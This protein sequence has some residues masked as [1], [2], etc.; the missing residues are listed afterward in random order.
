VL[1]VD[2]KAVRET[3]NPRRGET[4]SDA[5]ESPGPRREGRQRAVHA[6]TDPSNDCPGGQ[7]VN[8]RENADED[9]DPELF[10]RLHRRILRI[11]RSQ[12]RGLGSGRA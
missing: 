6:L 4:Q 3:R 5:S 12:D 7:H 10:S 1:I 2:S 8:R 11:R 9:Y